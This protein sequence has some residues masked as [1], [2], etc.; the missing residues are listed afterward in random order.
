M[1]LTLDWD[2]EQLKETHLP[3]VRER[4][5]YTEEQ[6]RIGEFI[7]LGD[8]GGDQWE[9]WESSSHGMDNKDEDG[10]HYVEHGLTH[11]LDSIRNVRQAFGDDATRII[12]DKDRT[13]WGSP[14][15]Q[16][17]YHMKGIKPRE[18]PPYETAHRAQL[19][20]RHGFG[21]SKE[22]TDELLDAEGGIDYPAVIERLTEH[23]DFSSRADL[24]RRIQQRRSVEVSTRASAR[25]YDL[26]N[27]RR[28]PTQA[29]R[30]ALR[31]YAMSRDLGHY[32][33]GKSETPG[34]PIEDLPTRTV[35][36]ESLPEIPD[37]ELDAETFGDPDAKEDGDSPALTA[38]LR[39]GSYGDLS[40][41]MLKEIHDRIAAEL[42]SVLSPGF[43]TDGDDG[44]EYIGLDLSRMSYPVSLERERP[45]DPDEKA[46]TLRNMMNSQ[47]DHS[48][49]WVERQ[50]SDVGIS[51]TDIGGN[52]SEIIIWE[53]L[54]WEEDYAG[55][56][57]VARGV[58]DAEKHDVQDPIASSAIIADT[59][60]WLK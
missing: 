27:E 33:D 18:L 5:P 35:F 56:W 48:R 51:P 28:K 43:W 60:G 3:R 37:I 2:T 58:L 12:A 9:L 1:R 30:K 41:A 24:F 59:R 13:E 38:G 57:W 21:T 29:E 23:P 7:G 46:M 25:A 22:A 39:T 14:Y 31:D 50:L 19:V 36:H 45:L 10:Y 32:V 34:S 52:D 11:D 47:P 40:E 16:V 4:N 20:E 55:Y 49:D 53:V 42:L 54:V 26:V 8:A 15:P 17:L 6:A 44:R